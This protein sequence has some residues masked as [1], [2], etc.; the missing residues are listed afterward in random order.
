MTDHQIVEAIKN[1][2]IQN[3]EEALSA[4]YDSYY[5]MIERFI[6]K[7]N[8]TKDDAKDVFQ[9]T[10]I[11]MYNNI[12]ADKYSADS[13]L[14]TYLFSIS[15]NTWFNKLKKNTALNKID[16]YEHHQISSNEDIHG[17]LE[18]TEHQKQIGMLLH[19]VGSD[20]TKLLKLFYFEK[21]RMVKI[22]TL[23][24]YASEKVAKNQKARCMKKLRTIVS[25]NDDLQTQLRN[26]I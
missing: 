10:I 23:M 5:G 19:K 4:I 18:Y 22:A 21:M 26:S 9:D 15:R 13:K 3:S 11:S 8:G 14:S 7:N 1:N 25:S 12:K 2:S 24:N 20:C 16:D 17:D 6:V